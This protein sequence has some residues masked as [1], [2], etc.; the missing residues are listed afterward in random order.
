MSNACE[1]VLNL[2]WS[3]II[4]YNMHEWANSKNRKKQISAQMQNHQQE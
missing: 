1:E 2:P 3:S 4:I